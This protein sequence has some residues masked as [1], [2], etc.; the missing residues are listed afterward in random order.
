MTTI[1]TN[2][3][4]LFVGAL[5]LG[6]FIIPKI[7][8]VVRFKQLMD[9]PNERSSHAFSTP[10]LGGVAFYII[11]MLSFYFTQPFDKSEVV[12][13]I[14][15]GLTILFIIGLKD[16][17]VVLS[18][19]SKLGAQIIAALF[20]V[21]HYRHTIESLH[22]FMGIEEMPN[23]IAAPVGVII[24]VAI[25]NAINLI[26]GIDGLAATV[27]IIMF[28][29]FG[30][31]FFMAERYFLMLTCVTMVG[32]LLAFL[33]FNLSQKNKIFMGDTGSMILGFLIG[34]M[35]VR[36]LALDHTVLA[37]L[38]FHHENL[39][40]VV[41]GI[42]I[43][44]LFDTV[45]VFIIRILNKR[46]PFSPDRN[47]IHHLIIDYF[48]VSHRRASFFI[49]VANFLFVLLFAFLAMRTEQ[50]QLLIIFTAVI[51]A[52]IIFFFILNRPRILRKIR[53]QIHRQTIRRKYFKYQN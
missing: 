22:G 34:V 20:L 23:F 11:V 32:V 48:D 36:L 31:L 12:M 27:G 51:F 42:L 45:R 50:W 3:L 43:V 4:G 40:F 38:P 5:L 24:V 49:G 33:R 30:T 1:Y 29:I 46:S 8:G 16:D 41:G 39:P 10:N 25:I 19:L 15:P 44:P 52:A 14:I 28:S 2:I 21:F 26:D 35:T 9:H 53:V 37:K 47:H 17:L 18:P 7:S 6:L 13:S